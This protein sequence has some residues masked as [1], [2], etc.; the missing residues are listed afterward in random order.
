MPPRSPSPAP[1][2]ALAHL[3]YTGV[4][5]L[6]CLPERRPVPAALTWRLIGEEGGPRHVEKDPAETG[7]AGY[8]IHGGG[9]RPEGVDSLAGPRRVRV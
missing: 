1:I 8:S 7:R 5:C 3:C 4:P 2:G 9:Q 6:S